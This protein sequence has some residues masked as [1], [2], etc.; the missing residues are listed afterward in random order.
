MLTLHTKKE[1]NICFL[2]IVHFRASKYISL[3]QSGGGWG[4]SSKYESL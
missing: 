3:H 2:C 1:A 4:T